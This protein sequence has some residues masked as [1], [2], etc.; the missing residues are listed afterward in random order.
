[1]KIINRLQVSHVSIFK[2]TQGLK[3]IR[4][5]F[6]KYI[7][8][9]DEYFKLF[10]L[11]PIKTLDK[12]FYLNGKKS[13]WYKEDDFFDNKKHYTLINEV[14]TKAHIDIYSAGKLIHTE[15]FED[16]QDLEQ[17]IKDNYNNCTIRYGK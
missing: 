1:M 11:F 14:Y 12:G 6:L 5:T 17:H 10:W 2:E 8:Y 16:Y 3:T 9:D 15:Y 13:S 4:G 7:Y